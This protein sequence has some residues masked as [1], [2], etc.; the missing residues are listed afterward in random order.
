MSY[1]SHYP[2]LDT[3][4]V[5]AT[6]VLSSPSY[7]PWLSCDPAQSVIGD[8]SLHCWLGGADTN[9]RYHID[10]GSGH[11]IKRLYYE[12]GH[13]TGGNTDGGAKTFTFWG[14]NSA[15]AFA[16]LT[17]ATDTDWT[18]LTTSQSTFDKHSAVNQV[19]P[20]YITVTNT[21]S[22]QYYAIKIADAWG[23][24]GYV[25]FRRVELQVETGDISI[26]A[27]PIETTTSILGSAFAVFVVADPFELTLMQLGRLELHDR[28]SDRNP[29]LDSEFDCGRYGNDGVEVGKII[30]TTSI[31]G[32][33]LNVGVVASPIVVT[34]SIIAG[35]EFA[36]TFFSTGVDSK[37]TLTVTIPVSATVVTLGS[38]GNW[39]KWSD[40]GH[41]DFT[42]SKANVAGERP[43]D[44]RGWVYGLKKLGD[45]VVA[46]GQ[47]GVSFLNPSG[48]T[49]G[50]QT[51]HRIG[52]KGRSAFCG[53]DFEHFFI[54]VKGRLYRVG[55]T[56]ELLDYSKYLDTLGSTVVMSLDD[57]NHLIYICDGL[58]GFV[59]SIKDKSL[60]TGPV[61]V[62]GVGSQSG[63]LYIAA[64]STISTPVFEICTDIYDMETRKNKTITSI[65]I[66]T[67]QTEDLYAT[68]DARV[69]KA[70]AF[71]TLSWVRVNPNGIVAIP[72]F[73]IEFRFRVKLLTYEAIK[74]DYIK[75]NGMIH[76]YSYLDTYTR[77]GTT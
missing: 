51:I 48:I 12:N 20:K 47:N 53:T 28:A 9:Q 44:W 27:D 41:L 75:V 61:N 72:C 43:L 37:I 4:H 35:D 34:T 52:L 29:E 60:G 50:L 26:T 8:W 6:S 59:Y 33:W 3:N 49:Y 13:S 70:A 54:D 10:L 17:Y 76:N 57:Q 68:V 31:L 66:G 56:L 69:N 22:Y 25:G 74:I 21:T 73:G 32:T 45:K 40:I 2:D 19:E 64:S 67:D 18:Q 39:V 30:V 5:K 16:D 63:T 58:V 24:L 55:P 65:E 23:T 46:Y 15:S 62:T 77:G 71:N 1:I 38:K 7:D 36:G 11:I 42:I 14:S